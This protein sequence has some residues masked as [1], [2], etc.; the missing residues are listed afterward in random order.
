MLIILVK[1][2]SFGGFYIPRPTIVRTP[3]S[4]FALGF[5]AQGGIFK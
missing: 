1:L 4:A 3:P 2:Y 5:S